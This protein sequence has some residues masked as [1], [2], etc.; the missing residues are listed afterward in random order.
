MLVETAFIE[1]REAMV[2]AMVFFSGDEEAAQDGV[3]QAFTQALIHR[4]ML[5]AMPEGAMKAW[6]YAAA[7]NAVVDIKRRERR[8]APFPR[9]DSHTAVADIRQADPAGKLMAEALLNALPAPLR[10]PVERKYYEGMNASEIGA[11][12]EISPA[13]IRTRLRTAIIRMRESIGNR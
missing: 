13:T 7:R 5:E 10:E 4:L 1:Y 6:L 11:A 3:S 9:E 8:F 12:M 2:R